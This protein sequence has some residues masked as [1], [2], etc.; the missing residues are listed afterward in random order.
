MNAPLPCSELTSF[1]FKGQLHF[2]SLAADRKKG[3]I[4]ET[5]R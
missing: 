1:V 3:S 5:T 4:Y 2:H